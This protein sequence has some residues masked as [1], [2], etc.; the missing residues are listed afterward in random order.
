MTGSAVSADIHNTTKAE[1]TNN[2]VLAASAGQDINVGASDSSTINSLAGSLGI[3]GTVGI[4]G[5]GTL[6]VIAN[7]TEADIAGG[8][9]TA[10]SALVSA[11]SDETVTT[12]AVGAGTRHCSPGSPARAAACSCWSARH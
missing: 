7:N 11:T 5:A 6:G 3:S 12:A 4:G 8:T 10:K 1:L 2:T 9:Y